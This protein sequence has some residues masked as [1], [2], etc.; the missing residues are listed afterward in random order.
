M[1]LWGLWRRRCKR[2]ANGTFQMVRSLSKK[3]MLQKVFNVGKCC[4][5]HSPNPPLTCTV[6][7][8][9]KELA[10][11]PGQPVLHSSVCVGNNAWM[12]KSGEER[13]KTWEHSNFLASRFSNSG[14]ALK[15]SR[16]DYE[17]IP[18]R[19]CAPPPTSSPPDVTH[20]MNVPVFTAL[21]RPC[22]IVNT[23]WRTK[24][25]VGLGTRLANS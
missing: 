12:Q 24:N 1:S 19:L 10:S 25:G 22:I 18:N 2:D 11:F 23:N 5:Y 6:G 8:H 16:L 21:P 4:F 15:P 3:C 17:L 9:C 13:G 14:E 20:V 7:R